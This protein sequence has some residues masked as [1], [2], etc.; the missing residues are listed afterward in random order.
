MARGSWKVKLRRVSGETRPGLPEISR[1]AEPSRLWRGELSQ[2]AA[3]S[4][5]RTVNTPCCEK[6]PRND[7]ERSAKPATRHIGWL[8]GA[9]VLASVA[10][11]AKVALELA[12]YRVAA[13]LGEVG[14]V[15]GLLEGPHVVGYLGVLL[16]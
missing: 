16:G 4:A 13:G 15:L 9:A 8:S 12:G 3:L 7:G 6:S 10:A 1:F 5:H 14:G 11:A 2:H